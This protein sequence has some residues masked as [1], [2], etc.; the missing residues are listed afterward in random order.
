M[1]TKQCIVDKRTVSWEE[2]MKYQIGD[3]VK[4]RKWGDMALEYGVDDDGD[5]KMPLYFIKKMEPFCGKIVT[6]KERCV[7]LDD[8]EHYEIMEDVEQEFWFSDDM[9]EDEFVSPILVG[10]DIYNFVKELSNK[11]LGN[12]ADM[13]D[14]EKAAYNLGKEQILSLLNQSLNELF[15]EEDNVITSTYIVHVPG[16]N[17]ATDFAS[18]DEIQE[19]FGGD[20]I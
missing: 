17:T 19:Q 6:I 20:K 2:R 18:I 15:L 11:F 9:F 5:I 8:E 1:H 3:K 13:T 12:K 7:D 4:V 14:G 10:I 16:L